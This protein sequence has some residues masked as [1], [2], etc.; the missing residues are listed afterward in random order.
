MPVYEIPLDDLVGGVLIPAMRCATE[1]RI[2]AG[3]FS[4][5]CLAQIAPGLAEL[6]GR[7]TTLHLLASTELSPE[8]WKGVERGITSPEDAIRAFAVELL[9]SPSTHLAAHATDCLAYLVAKQRLRI[10]FV[11]MRKGMYHKKQWLFSDGTHWAAVHGSGN[12]TARGLLANGEQMTVDRPWNDGESSRIRVSKLVDQFDR[13][14]NNRHPES[15]SLEPAQAIALLQKRAVGLEPPTVDDF[16][17]AWRKDAESGKEPV[18]PPGMHAYSATPSRLSIPQWLDWHR[19]PYSH[20]AAAIAQLEAAGGSGILSIATGGGKTRTSL[21]AVTRLQERDHRPMLLVVLVPST[22]LAMQWQE[23]V[24][25]FGVEPRLLSGSSPADRNETL[26]EVS[27]SLQGGN[28]TAVL[29]AS[30]QLFARDAD[31]RRF[32]E[33]QAMS[34]TTVLIGDE[35]HNL[36]APS[37]VNDPPQAFQFRIGL[38]A[39]PIRQYDPDGT[40]QLFDY[41]RAGGTAPQPVFTYTLEQAIKDGCLVPYRYWV[42]PVRFTDEEMDRYQELTDKL[43]AAGFALDDDGRLVANATVERLLRERRALIE[44]AGNKIPTLRSLLVKN[45]P[46]TISRTLI[47]AS[48]KPVV[49]PHADRQID[50]VTAMLSDLGVISHQFTNAETASRD[51]QDLLERFGRGDYQVLTAMKVLDEGI[52]IPQTNVAFLLASSTVQR[53]WVQ[54][55][56]RILRRAEGKQAADLH[57]FVVVPPDVQSPYGRRLL[58]GELGRVTEFGR[59]ALNEY[60]P[61]GA[62]DVARRL[63]NGTWRPQ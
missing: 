37:F 34:C 1:V 52:D 14:W 18:L 23:D 44:Q 13:Q 32:V 54:R 3:F 36:G 39:T 45:G 62:V 12:A 59:I 29:I 8:D 57:D 28:A 56:G 61:G 15:L 24:R 7:D 20:Q 38:S 17:N 48:A 41:F 25:D 21:V 58:R 33:R 40:D 49:A 6:L 43:R 19:P 63:E 10:R 42:H 46:H 53:E 51:A 50:T 27:A 35:V 9:Q 11:L 30:N 55:R 22:P 26:A 4:S 2:C 5:Q 31:L 60:D 16:W 47:Y